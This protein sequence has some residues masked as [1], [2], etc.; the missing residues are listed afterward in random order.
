MCFERRHIVLQTTCQSG[1]MMGMASSLR[2]LL[3]GLRHTIP[4]WCGWGARTSHAQPINK[5][6]TF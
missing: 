6:P 3:H 2:Q 4:W 5:Q 1:Q